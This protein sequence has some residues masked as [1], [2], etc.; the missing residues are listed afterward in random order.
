[1]VLYPGI[2]GLLWIL[3]RH[4]EVDGVEEVVPYHQSLVSA[5]GEPRLFPSDEPC[6]LTSSESMAAEMLCCIV[7]SSM[8][9]II[10]THGSAIIVAL[11]FAGRSSDSHRPELASPPTGADFGRKSGGT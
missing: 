1:M 4:T 7:S 10:H 6:L 5:S 8:T 11:L 2:P 3:K 9:P